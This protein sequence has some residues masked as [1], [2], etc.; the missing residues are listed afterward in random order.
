MIYIYIILSYTMDQYYA[1][2]QSSLATVIAKIT[3]LQTLM[4]YENY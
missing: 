2:V 4:H 1:N 3:V